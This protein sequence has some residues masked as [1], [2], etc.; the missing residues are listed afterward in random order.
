MPFVA[1]WLGIFCFGAGQI[2]ARPIEFSDPT[3]STISTNVNHLGDKSHDSLAAQNSLFGRPPLFG[4]RPDSAQSLQPIPVLSSAPPRLLNA[5]NG[6]KDW[7][8]MSP[9]EMVQTMME[10]DMRKAAFGASDANDPA[11][12][13]PMDKFYLSILEPKGKT[14]RTGAFL[15]PGE[16]NSATGDK[17][18]ANDPFGSYGSH[19]S[20]TGSP[21]NSIGGAGNSYSLADIFKSGGDLSSD[22]MSEQRAR[23]DQI[24][25]FKRSMDAT[26]PAAAQAIGQP[27]GAFFPNNGGLGNFQASDRPSLPGLSV[28]PQ[29][30]VPQAPI[31][32]TVPLAPGQ[33]SLMPVPAASRPKAVSFSPVQRPF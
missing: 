12:N 33:T 11:L 29:F 22:S 30:R 7:A 18:F 5:S 26:T 6:E 20:L 21:V 3:G 24:E 19:R 23:L 13:S 2:H 32:P 14:T 17:S 27:S 1:C 10:H 28:T 16:T 8:R 15:S 25:A 31:A 9:Q 4:G